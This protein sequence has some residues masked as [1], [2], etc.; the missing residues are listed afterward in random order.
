MRFK[1]FL[2]HIRAI[3]VALAGFAV[4]LPGGHAAADETSWV[5]DSAAGQRIALPSGGA[6]AEN[7]YLDYSE[8]GPTPGS[9]MT[10]WEKTTLQGKSGSIMVRIGLQAPETNDLILQ[11]VPRRGVSARIGSDPSSAMLTTFVFQEGETTDLPGDLGV[12]DPANRIIGARLFL[13]GADGEPFPLQGTASVIGGPDGTS[14]WS[15][16]AQT[17][18]LGAFHLDGEVAGSGSS[19]DGTGSGLALRGG[20]ATAA[21]LPVVPVDYHLNL[22][23]ERV[24][25]QFASPGFPD[26]ENNM[27][28]ASLHGGLSW[29][30]FGL[31]AAASDHRD[32]VDRL[33]GLPE[34]DIWQTSLSLTLRPRTI[35]PVGSWP[36]F[37]ERPLW[38][39]YYGTSWSSQRTEPQDGAETSATQG[40]IAGLGLHFGK[41]P[42][43]WELDWDLSTQQD[44]VQGNSQTR[45]EGVKLFLGPTRFQL[46]PFLSLSTTEGA[47]V[48]KTNGM[49]TGLAGLY[50]PQAPWRGNLTFSMNWQNGP[51]IREKSLQLDGGIGWFDAAAKAAGRPGVEMRLGGGYRATVSGKDEETPGTGAVYVQLSFK[52]PLFS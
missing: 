39:V 42:L 23:W 49:T 29:G 19:E 9:D 6:G 26:Q 18:I 30:V 15:L 10:D 27:E 16:A 17:K 2:L 50:Q 5:S 46:N 13:G 4:L 48:A 8:A 32:N 33:P 24:G 34:A 31:E 7:F 45:Q 43:A 11:N 25:A 36:F 44:V 20:L 3:S 35:L 14:A 47:G 28:N 40:N 38:N 1:R 52:I 51:G 12:D 37:L 21:R 41:P 22:D